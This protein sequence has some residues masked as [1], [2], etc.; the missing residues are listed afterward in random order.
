MVGDPSGKTELRK[1]MSLEQIR[2]N[3]EGISKQLSRY[4]DVEGENGVMLNNADWLLSLNYVEFLREI[5]RHFRVNEMLRAESYRARLEREEGLSFI[6][7]NYQL[8]QAYDFLRLFREQGCTL[9]IGG[10]D[11][12]GNILA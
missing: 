5:G 6:E 12:W 4:I 11:Q 9:Q 2:E 3:A 8:L 10:D 1:M 7:F